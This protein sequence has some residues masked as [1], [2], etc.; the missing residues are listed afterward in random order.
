M[1]YKRIAFAAT[2]L[3][4]SGGWAMAQNTALSPAT[5]SSYR[6]ATGATHAGTSADRDAS[7][8]G[9]GNAGSERGANGFT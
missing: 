4:G 7:A 8:I 5:S 6:S 9:V 3:F 1:H 2:L